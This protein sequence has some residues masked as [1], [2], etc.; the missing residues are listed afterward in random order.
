MQLKKLDVE[1]DERCKRRAGLELELEK[2]LKMRDGETSQLNSGAVAG[3]GVSVLESAQRE[4]NERKDA[5]HG[6]KVKTVNEI[7][8]IEHY[9]NK[10]QFY[11]WQRFEQLGGLKD[12]SLSK[13]VPFAPIRQIKRWHLIGTVVF[14]NYAGDLVCLQQPIQNCNSVW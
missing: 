1:I 3:G 9:D 4:T 12:Y 7:E 5:T 13:C 10:S 11:N 8:T 6:G 2:I 14:C